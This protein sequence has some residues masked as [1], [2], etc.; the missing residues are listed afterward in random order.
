MGLII[1]WDINPEI[2]RLGGFSIRWYGLLFAF[3]FLFGT[4]LITRF[5]KNEG[6]SVESIDRL[7]IYMLA[8]VVIGARL[9]E[10]LFYNPGY[11][12]R[13]PL[14]ILM[15][16]KGGL[17]SHG[18]VVGILV[19]VYFYSKKTPGQPYL[20]VLDR[21]AIIVALG[22]GLIRI[23][24]FINSEI[25]GR[26]TLGDWG[27]IFKR[28][29]NLPRHPAQLYESFTYL[30]LFVILLILYRIFETEKRQG[31]LLGVFLSIG[32]TARF[33][34][35]FVKESQTSFDETWMLSMGQWL[36]IPV[37]L[38]GVYLLARA[39]KKEQNIA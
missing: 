39:L 9:G 31:L 32:F 33:V 19:A 20:W 15:T 2:F 38:L 36:S 14:E 3:A 18:A 30:S 12:L 23:G 6:K 7:L 21:I 35:E 5:F 37:I 25:L 24:N 10:V 22:G 11:F 29:D 27:I 34:I 4:L 28:V 8:A 1:T 26:P 13:H 16:W 17:A